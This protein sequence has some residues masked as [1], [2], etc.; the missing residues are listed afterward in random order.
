MLVL[1]VGGAKGVRIIQSNDDGWAE[2]YIRS[3][4][5]AIVDA[6]YDA[7]VSAPADNESGKG[8]FSGFYTPVTS[9]SAM[10]SAFRFSSVW[11]VG[12][13]GKYSDLTFRSQAR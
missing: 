13:R 3:L 5:T 10:V 4:H 11:L 9:W 6:G 2:M 7:L 8:T 1:A 12:A